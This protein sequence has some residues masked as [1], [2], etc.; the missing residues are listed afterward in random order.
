MK[1][2]YGLKCDLPDGL[3]MKRREICLGV[4]NNKGW[5]IKASH[6]KANGRCRV[7][8]MCLS[9]LAMAGVVKMWMEIMSVI[10]GREN[11]LF[12]HDTRSRGR[13]KR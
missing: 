1:V 2:V 6:Q 3:K 9:D 5:V 12:P 11:I 13:G 10:R 4:L 7:R 8:R